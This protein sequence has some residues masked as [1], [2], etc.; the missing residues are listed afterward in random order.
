MTVNG[1]IVC[2]FSAPVVVVAGMMGADEEGS[3]GSE[4]DAEARHANGLV[5]LSLEGTHGLCA[6]GGGGGLLGDSDSGNDC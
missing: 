4:T 2:A 1:D 5:S 6:G 3:R